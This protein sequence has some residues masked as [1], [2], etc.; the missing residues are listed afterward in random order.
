MK[1]I[2]ENPPKGL[3]FTEKWSDEFNDFVKQCLLV[4]YN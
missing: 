4:E 3:T 2:K 1:K